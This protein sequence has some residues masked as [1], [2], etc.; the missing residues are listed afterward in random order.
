MIHAPGAKKAVGRLKT[1]VRC[2]GVPVNADDVVAADEDEGVVVPRPAGRTR[3]SWSS[4]R[5]AGTRC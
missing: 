4:P 2:G 3:A 1:E 5:P